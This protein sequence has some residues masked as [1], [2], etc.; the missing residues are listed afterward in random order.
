MQID[1]LIFKDQGVTPI[2]KETDAEKFQK[3]VSIL[4]IKRQTLEVLILKTDS[5]TIKEDKERLEELKAEMR[6]FGISE[7]DYQKFLISQKNENEVETG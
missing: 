7:I 2:L 4:C 5:P 1:P 6:S 3:I